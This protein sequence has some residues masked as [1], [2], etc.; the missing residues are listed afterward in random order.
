M[1]SASFDA[2]DP[3]LFI[4]Q[5]VFLQYF[6]ESVGIV[7]GNTIDSQ[8]NEFAHSRVGIHGVAPAAEFGV[9]QPPKQRLVN[10][11]MV[12]IDA[13]GTTSPV[14]S[15]RSTRTRIGRLSSLSSNL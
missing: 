2:L 5:T 15:T 8:L 3:R 11:P 1:G 12:E 9:V 7:G 10:N 13:N 4:P 6:H 14:R